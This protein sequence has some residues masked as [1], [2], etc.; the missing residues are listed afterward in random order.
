MGLCGGIVDR[1]GSRMIYIYSRR[2]FDFFGTAKFDSGSRT[3][4]LERSDEVVKLRGKMFLAQ[5]MELERN[6]TP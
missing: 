5:A 1:N 6:K 2:W 3:H 4:M